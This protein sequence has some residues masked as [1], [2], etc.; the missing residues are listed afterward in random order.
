KKPTQHCIHPQEGEKK[1]YLTTR[2]HCSLKWQPYSVTANS[3]ITPNYANFPAV[4]FIFT[5]QH[6][7]YSYLTAHTCVVTLEPTTYSSQSKV[8]AQVISST[9]TCTSVLCLF[10]KSN[11]PW[12]ICQTYRKIFIAQ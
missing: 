5:F 10:A 11:H 7:S 6:C 1:T 4:S 2:R 9:L 3:E 12:K 8:L